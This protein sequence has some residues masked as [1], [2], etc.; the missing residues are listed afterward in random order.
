MESY[1]KNLQK[2]YLV[3]HEKP[4]C[5]LKASNAESRKCLQS[6]LMFY[7]YKYIYFKVNKQIYI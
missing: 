1:L 6:T 2:L 3:D 7:I 4:F 5:A